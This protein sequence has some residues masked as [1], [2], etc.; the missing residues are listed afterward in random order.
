MKAVLDKIDDKLDRIY[1]VLL[2]LNE[3]LKNKAK[4]SN[5]KYEQA[6]R[7]LKS[8]PGLEVS[9]AGAP[10]LIYPKIYAS[11]GRAKAAILKMVKEGVLKQEG[12]KITIN[13]TK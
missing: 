11:R 8:I 2:E 3:S 12:W 5:G 7:Y 4:G 6:V 9:C 13:H 10:D 1:D